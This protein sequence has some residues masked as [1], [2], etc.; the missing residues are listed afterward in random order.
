MRK[1]Q[2]GFTL[3]ETLI[4]IF[5]MGIVLVAGGNIFF[6]IMK[7]ASRVEVER[8]V[9]QSGEYALAIME[10]MIKNSQRVTACSSGALEIQNP[11]DEMTTFQVLPDSEAGVNRIASS[12]AS[13][14]YLTGDNVNASDLV[15][16][17]T[18]DPE[19]SFDEDDI[20]RIDI[21]FTITPKGV[22]AGEVPPEMYAV[23]DFRT[24]ISLR[25]F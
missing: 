22:V 10:R 21:N 16:T 25:N 19:G 24:S 2:L 23:I 1:K 17:C 14:L 18:T 15:F 3:I 4:V 5:L 20:R 9:K 12:A 13:T 11:D 6:G 7:S 8:E